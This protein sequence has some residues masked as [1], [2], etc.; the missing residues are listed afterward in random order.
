MDT[1]TTGLGSTLT[2]PPQKFL[3]MVFK[4]Q[5]VY[6]PVFSKLRYVALQFGVEE[7]L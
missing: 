4:Y 2:Q 3:H 1:R 7:N 5:R 6:V